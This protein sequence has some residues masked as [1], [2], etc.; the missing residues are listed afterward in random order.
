MRFVMNK[1]M[2]DIAEKRSKVV[3]EMHKIIE[4]AEKEDRGLSVD[5]R[6]AWD[7]MNAEVEVYDQRFS[8]A[9]RAY[10]LGQSEEIVE[11]HNRVHGNDVRGG[12][13]DD[14]EQA[15]AALQEQAFRALIRS[16]EAG[17]AGL[18]S[19]IRKVLAER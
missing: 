18:P 1:Q 2:K 15:A 9:K 19:E 14:P 10:E 5:E 7:K 11:H 4:K 13:G 16:T 17:M 3:A 6:G 8:D 12:G